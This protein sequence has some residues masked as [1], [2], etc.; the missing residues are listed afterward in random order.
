[1]EHHRGQLQL[2]APQ[3]HPAHLAKLSLKL[4]DLA[5]EL[6]ALQA[7]VG[8]GHEVVKFFLQLTVQPLSQ[9]HTRP[10]GWEER[11]R[12]CQVLPGE[13]TDA[14]GGGEQVSWSAPELSPAGTWTCPHP[15]EQMDGRD[16]K[17]GKP[18]LSV[19]PSPTERRELEGAV[20]QCCLHAWT[21]EQRGMA[22]PVRHHQRGA[23]LPAESDITG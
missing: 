19:Q 13:L 14:Q 17:M 11:G 5:E 6:Q 1:M 3:G 20:D 18:H 23:A 21:T 12:Q 4:P 22:G 2:A 8:L 10:G 15:M 7:A 9:L 16:H